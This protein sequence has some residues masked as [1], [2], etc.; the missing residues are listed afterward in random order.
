MKNNFVYAKLGRKIEKLDKFVKFNE[1]KVNNV[2][3]QHEIA[4][5]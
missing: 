3:K 2:I 4:E 5:V 1:M